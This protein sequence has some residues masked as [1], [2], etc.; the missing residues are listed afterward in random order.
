MCQTH[1]LAETE[2]KIQW[3]ILNS[4]L[5]INHESVELSGL[6]VSTMCSCHHRVKTSAWPLLDIICF[7]PKFPVMFRCGQSREAEVSLTDN[8]H[9]WAILTLSPLMLAFLKKKKTSACTASSLPVNV[10][11]SSSVWHSCLLL[12]NMEQRWGK[13]KLSENEF[14]GKASKRCYKVKRAL[15]WTE[16]AFS[17]SRHV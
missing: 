6:E 15:S 5:K 8:A 11:R 7:R 14:T 17:P 1:G 2:S 12:L 4:G 3:H 10:K 16:W 13:A 9:V